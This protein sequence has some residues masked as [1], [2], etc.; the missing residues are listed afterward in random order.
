MNKSKGIALGILAAFIYGFTPILGKLTYLEG[1]NTIS[2]AFYRG[3]LS[4]PFFFL[5]LKRKKI[6]FKTE[7][8][9]TKKLAIL[10][11][12]AS[13]TSLCLYG[14]YN[15]IS[16]GMSTTIHYIYP[17]LVVAACII[18]F[19]ESISREKLI[20]LILSTIGITLFFEGE[21][22]IIGIFLS[23][24]SG[25]TFASYLLY[26]D[27]SGLNEVYPF[28]ITFYTAAFTSIYIF[29]FGIISGSLVFKMSLLGWF[30]TFI[31]AIS[32]SIFAN[33]FIFLAVKYVGPT[34]TSIVGMFE[35]ITSII[36]GVLFLSEPLTVR[37]IIAC[38]LI[39][40]G[41]LIV[42]LSNQKTKDTELPS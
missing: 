16:V 24:L 38:I 3:F 37:N 20:S 27:K 17:V 13:M 36:F 42:T 35:P 26:M 14:S 28:V 18:V 23:L 31:V 25:I 19:K 4:M 12:L 32:V 9:H 8:V 11:F 33:T 21:I 29:I 6:P 15:Y 39:L 7:K 1:S 34:V 40:L 22:N 10:A 30:Y 5:M 2:L 41:V